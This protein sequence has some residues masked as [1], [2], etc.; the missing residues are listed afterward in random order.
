M[1][2]GTSMRKDRR[3][4]MMMELEPYLNRL[5]QLGM[6]DVEIFK[7]LHEVVMIFANHIIDGSIEELE[8][9]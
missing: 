1:E 6:T 5:R 3:D 7:F 8:N 2:I 4:L 9:Q